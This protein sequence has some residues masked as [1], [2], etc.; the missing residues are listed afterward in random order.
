MEFQNVEGYFWQGQKVRL[1]PRQPADWESIYQE[2]TDSEGQRLLDCTL[3]LPLSPEMAQAAAERM[4]NF[5]DAGAFVVFGVET[6]SGECAGTITLHSQNQKDGTFSFSVW[7]D[8][9]H[10]RQ[11]YAEEATR[12]LLRYAFYELRYQKCNSASL[13]PN[14]ASVRLHQKVGF[15]EEGRRRRNRYTNGRYYDEI[16]FGLTREEFDVNEQRR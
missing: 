10:R 14:P 16:L 12:I 7:V 3:E 5:K 2:S 11:G 1:R 8:R 6:L 15:V 4:A 13:E 9:P